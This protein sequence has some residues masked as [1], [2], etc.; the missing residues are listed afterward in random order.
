MNESWERD[1]EGGR[2]WQFHDKLF[3]LKLHYETDVM[4][5]ETFWDVPQQRWEREI[6]GVESNRQKK[7]KQRRNVLL[8]SQLYLQTASLQ[9]ISVFVREELADE[10]EVLLSLPEAPGSQSEETD[11]VYCFQTSSLF[12]GSPLNL[13]LSASRLFKHRH[14]LLNR[15]SWH[16]VLH[17]VQNWPVSRLKIEIS[18]QLHVCQLEKI[19]KTDLKSIRSWGGRRTELHRDTSKS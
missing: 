9:E 7:K 14:M 8:S 3:P 4:Y 11:A 13:H 5:H 10:T 18:E 15:G 2:W 1:A 17:L 12:S 6:D 16:S 19:L